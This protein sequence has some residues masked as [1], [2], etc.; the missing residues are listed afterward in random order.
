VTYDVRPK[1]QRQ[2]IEQRI[3]QLRVM[4]WSDPGDRTEIEGMIEAA[5]A[6]LRALKRAS[7]GDHG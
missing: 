3:K 7:G 4:L 1:T 5:E 6:E 2:E